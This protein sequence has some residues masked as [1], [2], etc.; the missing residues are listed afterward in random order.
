MS[1]SRG[2]KTKLTQQLHDEFLALWDENEESMGEMAAFA[3]TCQ[4]LGLNEDEAYDL[5]AR[6]A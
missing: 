6:F 1:K 3:V 5:M 2:H 4:M